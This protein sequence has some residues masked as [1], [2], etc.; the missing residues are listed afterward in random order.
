MGQTAAAN[1]RAEAGASEAGL[2]DAEN[3]R[4]G[5]TAREA[6][7]ALRCELMALIPADGR[8]QVA[9]RQSG[10][11]RSQG[12]GYLLV[13]AAQLAFGTVLRGVLG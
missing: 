5:I 8:A 11:W 7:C 12:L 2:A 3:K 13:A 1:G 9:G 10:D 6:N 4:S